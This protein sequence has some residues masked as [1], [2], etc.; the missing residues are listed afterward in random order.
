MSY[1]V[2]VSDKLAEQGLTILEQ[3]DGIEVDYRPG[4]GGDELVRI[5]GDYDALII[6]S[7]TKVTAEVIDAATS[8]KVIGRAGIGVDNVD[9]DAASKRG[10]VVMNT[11]GGNNVTT[12]EHTISLML[13]LARHIPQANAS[14]RAGEWRRSDFVGTELC[15]KTLGIIGIGNIGSIV[16]DRARGLKMKV[17]AYDPFITEEAAAKL[18]IE[19]VPLDELYARADFITVHTPLTDDTRGMIGDEAFAKMRP[20]VRIINCARGGIVDEAALARALESGKVAGAALDVFEQEPPPADHPLIQS[21]KV[22]ATPHLGASTGEAQLN[23]AIAIAEQVRDYLLHGVV[24]HALNVPS[25]APEQ[26][27]ILLPYVT[28]GEKI[29]SLY[30]QLAKRVP[31][32]VRIEYLGEAAEIDF[33]PVNA[34]VLKG[35]LACVM[36]PPVNVVNAPILAEERGI[37]VVDV[38][39]RQATGFSNAIRVRFSASD[40]S[41]LIE[42]AVFGRDIIRLVR[43]DDFHFEAIPEGHILV[44]RNRDVR[45]VV[46]RIG[47]FLAEHDVNI[48]GLELGRIGG[49]A[50]QF[51]HIDSPLNQEQLGELRKLPD[52]IAADSVY[53]G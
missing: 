31:S 38:R 32:E 52:I 16:A 42:G 43:F 45:G 15:R 30:A 47:T 37:K 28:L 51:V 18:G 11:P 36:E 7:G 6:R 44:V 23:V 25:V 26:A 53:L 12:A 3:A 34:A 50:I 13:A 48:G 41:R 24:I 10:I 20:G 19:L 35:L 17:I 29:G 46:G 40:G 39:S 21:P 2:L 9:V 5:I 22:V 33:R 4:L 1:R 49:E 27:G 14:L 8:L